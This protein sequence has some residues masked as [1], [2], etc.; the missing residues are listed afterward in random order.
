MARPVTEPTSAAADEPTTPEIPEV[1]VAG[2]AIPA[3]L[4]FRIL[5]AL[6]GTYPSLTAGRDDEGVVRAVLL[7]WITTTLSGYEG[8]AV[9]TETEK[10]IDQLRKENVEK[11]KKASE[12]AVVDASRIREA[13][14]GVAEP[15]VPIKIDASDVVA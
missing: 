14:S 15:N 1:L 5:A 2:L 7:Y 9:Y 6:R 3:D 12:K 4:A 13:P 8:Q 10:A 11:A